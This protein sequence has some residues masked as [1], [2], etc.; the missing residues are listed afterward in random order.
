MLHDSILTQA[1][2]ARLE[3]CCTGQLPHGAGGLCVRAK[4]AEHR[5]F[6]SSITPSGQ[7]H[8]YVAQAETSIMAIR[9][10]RLGAAAL[11]KS[12]P[13]LQTMEGQWLKQKP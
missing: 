3:H 11:M 9:P 4:P 8:E 1:E 5:A 7:Q 13:S 10:S 6:V 12:R 2:D